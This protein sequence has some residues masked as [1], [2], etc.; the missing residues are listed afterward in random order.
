MFI[1][2]ND[3]TSVQLKGVLAGRISNISIRDLTIFNGMCASIMLT[4]T[5]TTPHSVKCFLRGPKAVYAV[6]VADK[7]SSS[8]ATLM[9]DLD[10]FV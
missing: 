1:H 10:I 3:L 8:I 4:K 6:G 7:A 9:T 5:R 2:K